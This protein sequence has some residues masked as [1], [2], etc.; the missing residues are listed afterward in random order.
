MN[1]SLMITIEQY[2]KHLK[3]SLH[4]TCISASYTYTQIS[5]NFPGTHTLRN[6]RTTLQQ[7][8]CHILCLYSLLPDCLCTAPAACST[9]SSLY[10]GTT[11]RAETCAALFKVRCIRNRAVY[12]NLQK[13]LSS[14]NAHV[15]SGVSKSYLLHIGPW[16]G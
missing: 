2:N 9:T 7:A 5:L 6:L 15:V 1:I 16:I 3:H 11:T 10:C 13:M 4:N 8:Y 12:D 14:I